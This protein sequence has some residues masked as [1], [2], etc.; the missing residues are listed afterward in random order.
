[1]SVDETAKTN[2][3][4]GFTCDSNLA[5]GLCAVAKGDIWC[6]NFKGLKTLRKFTCNSYPPELALKNLFRGAQ[7]FRLGRKKGDC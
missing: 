3:R 2:I 1:V 7:C 4:L 6:D 5:M